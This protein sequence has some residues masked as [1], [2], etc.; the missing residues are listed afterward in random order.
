MRSGHPAV[1]ARCPQ[2][3]LPLPPYRSAVSGHPLYC[4]Q[5]LVISF[6]VCSLW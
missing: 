1:T 4:R 2:Y 5:S 6:T 3:L